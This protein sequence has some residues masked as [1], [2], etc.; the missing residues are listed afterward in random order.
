MKKINILLFFFPSIFGSSF[1]YSS[2]LERDNHKP[3]GKEILY[4]TETIRE[5][6]KQKG[7]E[8][9]IPENNLT[10]TEAYL[11]NYFDLKKLPPNYKPLIKKL[12]VNQPYSLKNH[13]ENYVQLIYKM[14]KEERKYP[15]HYV[16]YRGDK[17]KIGMLH[18]ILNEIKQILELESSKKIHLRFGSP[19][20][21]DLNTLDKFLKYW[22]SLFNLDV[23]KRVASWEKIY[24]KFKNVLPFPSPDAFK[25]YWSLTIQSK[26][27]LQG[28]ND[29]IEPLKSQILP[30]NLSVFGNTGKAGESTLS[31]FISAMSL[32][33]EKKIL[34]N[35]IFDPFG[36][37]KKYIKEL[38]NIYD[39]YI[40]P[41][42][43]G[44]VLQIFIPKDKVNKFVFLCGALG[45]LFDKRLFH[46]TKEILSKLK[47]ETSIPINEFKKLEDFDQK[48]NTY[49]ISKYLEKYT[50]FPFQ[51]FFKSGQNPVTGQFTPVSG[52]VYNPIT[53]LYLPTHT[54]THQQPKITSLKSLKAWSKKTMNE[55]QA[56]IVL[57][58]DFFSSEH[59]IL[60][61][62]YN[63]VKEENKQI[64]KKKLK[65]TIQKMIKQW[66]DSNT[67]KK[68]KKNGKKKPLV[69]LLEMIEKGEAEKNKTIPDV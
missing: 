51:T 18:D 57:F 69:N 25:D 42:F 66:I 27:D 45:I 17:R 3:K 14:I 9:Q 21:N 65:E 46:P 5:L 4:H 56:R 44:H 11:A 28:L 19:I 12:L 29:H 8:I 24:E 10:Q 64:Y 35:V 41:K 26:S 54:A 2:L 60:I 47:K 20:P 15:N 63:S 22:T 53:N 55:L 62:R 68:L 31:F 34:E 1:L 6:K 30:V 48:K 61:N 16:F 59:K 38:E 58:P 50:T 43:G 33:S 37:D 7:L 67:W 13:I 39:K 40:Q 36:F 52:M 49:K 32:Q 23:K